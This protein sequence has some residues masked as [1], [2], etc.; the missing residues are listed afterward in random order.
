MNAIFQVQSTF[1]VYGNIQK[2]TR[3]A[4]TSRKYK[5]SLMW[6]KMMFMVDIVNKFKASNPFIFLEKILIIR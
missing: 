1:Q 5:K 4:E 3:A 2:N 6:Y